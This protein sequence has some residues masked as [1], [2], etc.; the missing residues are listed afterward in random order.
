MP[1]A[2]VWAREARLLIVVN[3]GTRTPNHSDVDDVLAADFLLQHPSL[4]IRFADLLGDGS[5][6][7][8]LP[9]ASE[10]DSTEEALL[11]W[12]RAVAAR[13][14]APMLGRLIARGLVTHDRLGTLRVTPHGMATAVRAAAQLEPMRL[15]RIERTAAAFRDDPDSVNERLRLVLI[16][17]IT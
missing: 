8:L 1:D 4:L 17:A 5:R 13:V 2:R 16:E 3:A 6:F 10:A 9:S 14:V 7:W 12:K 15:E 11:R